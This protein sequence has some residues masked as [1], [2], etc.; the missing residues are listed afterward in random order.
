MSYTEGLTSAF[1]VGPQ[2]ALASAQAQQQSF[3]NLQQQ[4]VLGALAS[5]NL[6]D[7][8]STNNTMQ[9]LTRV[10]A[11]EQAAALSNLGRARAVNA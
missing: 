2:N 1:G 11:L 10:G 5:V 7:P 4:R 6:D 9:S 8:N 3:Q